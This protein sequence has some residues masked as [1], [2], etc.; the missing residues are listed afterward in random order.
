MG[1]RFGDLFKFGGGGRR[2]DVN[3]NA[4][5][6]GNYTQY[7]PATGRN[8]P[9]SPDAY[10][11]SERNRLANVNADTARHQNLVRAG[12]I[13]TAA[14]FG[15][16]ALPAAG[17]A[18]GGAGAAPASGSSFG[19]LLGLGQLAAGLYGNIAGRNAQTK[20]A[21]AAAAEQARQFEIQLGLAKEAERVRQKEQARHDAEALAQWQAQQKLA[22]DQW[23]AQEEERL[24]RRRL[25][26]EAEARK[27][28]RRAASAQAL[29]RLQDLIRL[30]RG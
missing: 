22:E 14:G 1:L 26:D 8:E 20:A 18:G 3:A 28:P 2:Y 21:E 29:L 25:Q 19:N 23:K 5:P 15:A 6:A 4:I 12:Q 16:A 30:G 10:N 17:A 7:N 27:A 13:A 11:A 9:W 24:Y